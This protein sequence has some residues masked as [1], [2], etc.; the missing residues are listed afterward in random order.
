MPGK[1]KIEKHKIRRFAAVAAVVIATG[2]GVTH[3]VALATNRFKVP[4]PSRVAKSPRDQA[5]TIAAQGIDA[6]NL[7]TL[8]AA[9]RS[10]GVT[11]DGN[12]VSLSIN[13]QLQQEVFDLFRRFDPPYGVFAA[14]EPKTGRV[15][16]LVGYRRGGESDPGLALRAIYPAASLVKMITA[17]AAIEK[18][19]VDPEADI[20][21]CGSIYSVS[22]RANHLPPGGGPTMTL[23]DAISKSANVVFGKVTVN[24]VGR[25]GLE[26]YLGK[27]GFGQAV[28][29]DLP[30]EPSRSEVPSDELELARTGAGFGE[31]YVSPLHMA[32]IMA[33]IG[34]N[35]AMPRP[36][37]IDRIE[38]RQGT[39]MFE[40]RS[41]KLRDSIRPE[42]AQTLMKMM[43]KT[44][45]SGTS[46]H[47]FG[48]PASTPMLRDMEVA[49]KTGTL[50]GWT[51]RMNFEWFAGVAP[52]SDP[53][54]ALV[55][56]VVNDDHW[57]IKGNYV[58]KEAFSA[59]FGYPSSMPP[60]Y[61]VAK[62]KR[63]GKLITVSRKKRGK[64]AKLVPGKR[65]KAGP[66]KRSKGVSGK[67][68]KKAHGAGKAGGGRTASASTPG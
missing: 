29:F 15:V 63:A 8:L 19:G 21:Y 44:I 22:R 7:L 61:S 54:L 6:R 1:K 34:D 18:G 2:W 62:A 38:D 26:Q 59:Y 36:R 67:H 3:G 45:E 40:G 31:V 58:G 27:Y 60:I 55:A 28:P 65:G 17:S 33:S 25:E 35:G 46:R 13:P 43:V 48:S 64:H 66:G 23:S 56:L 57:R 53:K 20:S 30:V 41:E 5:A 50:S 39:V 32:M 42:T 10:E 12:K 9:A 47:A 11:P 51:P 52:V 4:A 14:V 37:L 16:A 68:G 24:H 49:G